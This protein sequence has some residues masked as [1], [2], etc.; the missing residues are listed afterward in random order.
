MLPGGL[1]KSYPW[2]WKRDP[3]GGVTGERGTQPIV[4]P[5]KFVAVLPSLFPSCW[6]YNSPYDITERGLD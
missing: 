5:K 1:P 3:M 6:A 2:V 4:G